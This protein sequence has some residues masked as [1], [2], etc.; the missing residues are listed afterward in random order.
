M[1]RVS[2][3]EAKA[4]LAALVAEVAYGGE[5]VIIQRRGKPMA[6]LVRVEELEQLQ[7]GVG[8]RVA[9]RGFLTLLGA[10]RDIPDSEIDQW[11]TDVYTGREQDTG[12]AVD[13]DV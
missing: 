7:Q 4:R 10:W 9:F 13:L 2:A 12:R 11:L 5:H 1:K 8:K 6:A 3:A